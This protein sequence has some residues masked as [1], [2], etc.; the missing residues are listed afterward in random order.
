MKFV[1]KYGSFSKKGC[2][3][4]NL[5]F[6]HGLG[7]RHNRLVLGLVVMARLVDHLGRGLGVHGRGLVNLFDFRLRYVEILV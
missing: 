6:G 2:V 7:F 3:L 5:V 1:V 4:E